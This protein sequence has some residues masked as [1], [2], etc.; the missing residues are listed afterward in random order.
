M[1]EITL[2]EYFKTCQGPRNNAKASFQTATLT[3]IDSWK[4]VELPITNW[5]VEIT[6]KSQSFS[7]AS[8][9]WFEMWYYQHFEIILKLQWII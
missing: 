6:K 1:A 7:L 5:C 3:R 4:W 2:L 8:Q 9:K